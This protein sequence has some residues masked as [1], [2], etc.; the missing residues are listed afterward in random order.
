MCIGAS[1]KYCCWKV[2][3]DNKNRAKNVAP[4]NRIN[5]QFLFIGIIWMVC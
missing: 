3:N 1:V 5:N 2:I 4:A